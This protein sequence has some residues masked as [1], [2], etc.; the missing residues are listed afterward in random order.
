MICY[1][2]Q[3]TGEHKVKIYGNYVKGIPEKTVFYCKSC[4]DELLERQRRE[5]KR[6]AIKYRNH[7]EPTQEQIERD[8]SREYENS[9]K[10]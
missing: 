5:N 2:C 8:L 6:D 1:L 9:V 4:Y 7:R 3:N 10:I